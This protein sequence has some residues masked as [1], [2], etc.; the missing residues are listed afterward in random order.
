MKSPLHLLKTN[1][2]LI[3]K[4]Y[5]TK[6]LVFT[7]LPII[8]AL[9]V[10]S[11]N[12]PDLSVR[13]IRRLPVLNYVQNS[14]N[15]TVE[16]WPAAG[17]A[18]QWRA[19]VKNWSTNSY[20]NV[21]YTWKK[22]GN[23]IKTGTLD[24]SP[25]S[26]VTAVLD[27]TWAF[28]RD[29]ITFTIDNANTISETSEAN[30]SLQIYT[31]A[32]SVNFYVEQSLYDYFHTYQKD[33]GVQTNSWDDWAQM[34]QVKR[35]NLMF[36][37]A[38]FPE[39]PNGVLDRIRV[40]SIVIVP[41]GSLPLAG[42]LA[43]NNPNLNDYTVDLQWG[44][45]SN[46]VNM[47]S[48]HA[49][50]ADDNPFFYEGSLIHELGHA[51]YLIDLY[52]FDIKTSQVHINEGNIPIAGSALMPIIRYDVVYYNKW[53][54]FMSGNYT[55][56]SLYEVLALNRI[57]HKRAVCG[58]YNAPCNIGEFINDLPQNNIL[59][60]TDENNNII[61]NACVEVY[62]ASP[63]NEWYGKD[64]DDIP[65]LT[66]TTNTYGDINV[67][68]N[69]FSSGSLVHT[70]GN[71][72][73]D[74]IIRVEKNN[75]VGY[76]VI[77]AA[78]FNV[79]YMKGNVTN[80]NYAV[81]VN[82]LSCSDFSGAVCNCITN[83]YPRD[84]FVDLSLTSNWTTDAGG[85]SSGSSPAN[86]TS[87]NQIFNIQIAGIYR[88][89]LFVRAPWTISGGSKVV[90]NHSYGL[91][92]TPGG[93][94]N[95]GTGSEVNFNNY[96]VTLK[97]DAAGTAS[98]GTISGLLLNA[99]NVTVERYISSSGNR[100]YRLLSPS[101]TTTSTIRTNWQENGSTSPGYGTH[102][103]GSTT[104]ANGFDATITGQGS[105]FNYNANTSAWIPASNT[106]ATTLDALQGY[107]LYIRGDRTIDLTS[108]ASPLPSNNT[109]LRATG[110]L[111]TG[112]QTFSGLIGNGS[113][114]GFNLIANPYAS[115]INW[116]SVYAAGTGLSQ[117][118]T[119]WDPNFGTRGGYVTVKT[120]GTKTVGTN[121]DVNIQSGQAFF[122]QASGSA[123]PAV[124][125]QETHKSATNNLDVFRI[126]TQTESLSTSLYFNDE[127]NNRRIADGVL[128]VY[129]NSYSVNMDGDDALQIANWDED[130]AIAR[131]G[132]M[133]SIESRPLIDN[134]DTIPLATARLKMQNYE[135]Q[136]TPANFSH[137]NLQA[138]LV[139]K[140][141]VTKTA[142]SLTATTIIPFSVTSNAA[143]SA[144]DRFMVVFSL[145]ST[146]PVSLTSVAAYQKLQGVQVEWKAEAETNIDRYE[147]EKSLN[148][149]QFIK[150]AS[151]AAKNNGTTTAYDWFDANAVNGNNF[152]RIKSI[153]RAGEEK[154]SQVVRVNLSNNG[155]EITVYPN[156]LKGDVLSLYLN[157]NKGRYSIT[158][159]NKAGQQ[160]YKQIIE[161]PGGSA[162]QTLQLPVKLA[163]AVYQLQVSSGEKTYT[164]QIIKN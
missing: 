15:P 3:S 79:E 140:F 153:S 95:I 40:D 37:N 102:I 111:L 134:A 150:S 89:N 66:F 11:Q 75:K 23:V 82:M 119:Y 70:Y 92:F 72:N 43:T 158:L 141:L 123:S 156:P 118:Y 27:D 31:N 24:F 60:I 46:L 139:D 93:S 120:D 149:Q 1:C 81:K 133:L 135:W 88:A 17:Q 64:F 44:F 4:K 106:N 71:S 126:G 55:T 80:A 161:H 5:V 100:A 85:G 151:V 62:R 160:I 54:S 51:R 121:A 53:Q 83:Y 29:S 86:F 38:I 143:S 16:G 67:G 98:I 109:T 74:V 104:G 117:F 36:Q 34:L 68:R 30:N 69:P 47:Y 7:L 20:T 18:I 127:N 116:A 6:K 87:A 163:N 12:E 45:P 26:D 148:S 52:G 145:G 107:L 124:S 103:T 97:S 115:A 131:P 164:K 91:T 96:S 122:V 129:N 142:I 136:F 99:T 22:N 65:D 146:L 157:L 162:T 144:A 41:D 56:I 159:T 128:S 58:N 94:L 78:D 49:S 110:R 130:I 152:Y 73:M 63:A 48:N 76:A 42:G 28:Q 113:G 90:L 57:A 155:K 8:I 154:Y 61:S 147:I 101:V 138:F 39:A 50:T 137:P 25:Y 32:I 9:N 108:T 114:D 2:L 59:K 10:F 105:L 84:A 19:H 77:E 14:A 125:I 33:L 112:T 21:S 35:W 13:F 132:K